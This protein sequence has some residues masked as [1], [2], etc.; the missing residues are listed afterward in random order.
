VTATT[1]T[2]TARVARAAALVAALGMVSR[3]LGLVREQVIA[4]VYGTSGQADAYVSSLY[5]VNTIAAVLLYVAV[6]LVIPVFQQERERAGTSSAW[7]LLS[8]LSLWIG[9]GLV[10]ISAIVAIW[11]HAIAVLFALT[12]G[13]AL[14]AEHLLRIMAPSI[15][16]Q[17]LSAIL[18]ALLQVYGRFGRPAAVGVAFNLG[19]IVCVLALQGSIGIEA[20]AW[21]VTIG[22]A[23]QIALQVPD[24][25]G[26]V[27]AGDVRPAARHPQMRRV[28]VLA[29]PVL[30]ASVLQQVNGYTDRLFANTLQAGRTA[31]LNYANIIGSGP[32]TALLFP[33]LT[34]L[35]PLIA[36]FAAQERRQDFLRAFQRGAGLLGL[37]SVPMSVLIAIYATEITTLL[38]RY[39]T[40]FTA[41]SVTET[42]SPLVWYGLATWGNFIGY[43]VNRALSAVSGFHDILIATVVA[44]VLT[45]ALDLVLLG[46]M[47][48]A[49]LALASAIAVYVNTGLTLLYLRRR[50][51][52]LSLRRFGDQ[53]VRLMIAGGVAAAAALVLNVALPTGHKSHVTIAVLLTVKVIGALVAY[54]GAVRLLAPA[55]LADGLRTLRSM[56]PRRRRAV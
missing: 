45:I 9:A 8:A 48:Q 3:L 25:V 29:V 26:L 49:G 23:L 43:L 28:A 16:L 37:V 5:V 36:G 10:A 19:I 46:P 41:Q 53:Q 31:A 30:V 39:G 6:T 52:E 17:G 11:P 1:S 15:L 44:V 55:L 47:E 51:P 34:P 7:S 22:A 56:R 50:Y 27:R 4:I 20:A 14:V 54:L 2:T 33:L 24:L 35:F 13:R 38:F 32:R 18:T 21:G 40:H 42:A 12:G